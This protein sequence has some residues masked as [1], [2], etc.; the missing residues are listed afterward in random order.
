M[1]AVVTFSIIAGHV[2]CEVMVR[3]NHIMAS[4]LSP[5]IH[6]GL[7]SDQESFQTINARNTVVCSLVPG[8]LHGEI[9]NLW[10]N[11]L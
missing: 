4:L 2:S 3:C 7:A 5:L 10:S 11:V 9:I 8:Q 6:S 1:D